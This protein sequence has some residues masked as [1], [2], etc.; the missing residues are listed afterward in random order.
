MP[1]VRV[2]LHMAE[3]R[4]VAKENREVQERL[5]HD[6][7][8][9]ARTAALLAPKLTGALAA[10]IHAEEQSDG[11][12]RVSWDVDHRYGLFQELGTETNPPQ[13]FLRPAAKRFEK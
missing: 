5:R 2:K 3:I 9:I 11:T 4:R 12:W 6:A 13:P 10:S 1:V 7:E 8:Q